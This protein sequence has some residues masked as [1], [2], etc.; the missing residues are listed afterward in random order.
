MIQ[1]LA[2]DYLGHPSLEKCQGGESRR[3]PQVDVA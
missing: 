3:F 1:L 2:L